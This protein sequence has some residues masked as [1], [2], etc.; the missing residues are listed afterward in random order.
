M[1]FIQFPHSIEVPKE[2]LPIVWR[3]D[4]ALAPAAYRR[5][6]KPSEECGEWFETLAAPVGTGSQQGW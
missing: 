2:L 1:P 3:A 4:N 5:E 6:G